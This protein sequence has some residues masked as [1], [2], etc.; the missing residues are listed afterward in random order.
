MAYLQDFWK[1]QWS[2]IMF[3][4][5]IML[6]LIAVFSILGINFKEDQHKELKKIVTIEAFGGGS[7][8]SNGMC[9]AYSND[10]P[11]LEKK[12]T[13]LSEK[14]CKLTSCCGWLN[15]TKCVAGNNTGPNYHSNGDKPIT[16]SSWEFMN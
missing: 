7:D 2:N 8:F 15:K 14:N 10:P 13:T 11:T 16:L 9:S 3:F 1:D 12:C 5:V 4:V 6:T